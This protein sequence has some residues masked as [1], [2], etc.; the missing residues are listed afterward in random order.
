MKENKHPP[1]LMYATKLSVT[2]EGGAKAFYVKLKLK[3]FMSTKPADRRHLKE[4]CT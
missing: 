3:A 2:I 4:S 1:R